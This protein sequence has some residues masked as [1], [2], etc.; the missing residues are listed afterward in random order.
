MGSE[1]WRQARIA[2][3]TAS[4]ASSLCKPKGLSISYIREKVG[5]SITRVP[6]DKEV[7]TDAT[8]WGILYEN[9]AIKKFGELKG[10]KF[11]VTQT[12]ICDPD[13][14][15]SATP[16]FIW[17]QREN[18]DGLSYEVA[19]GEVKCFPSYSHYVE[20]AECETPEDVLKADD[21][22]FWQVVGQM[23]EVDCLVGYAVFYHPD[24]TQGG[25]R[26]IEFRKALLR[27]KFK[28]YNERKELAES[29]FSRVRNKLLN[30]KN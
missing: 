11:L 12:M 22:V 17:V 15:F 2:K 29:E 30:I 18:S 13:S 19:C 21:E 16:D 27:E 8:R 25:M 24:F 3:F 28:F 23:S 26:V 1:E 6:A 20:M 9:E 4:K 14:M 5:E 10:V 7:D